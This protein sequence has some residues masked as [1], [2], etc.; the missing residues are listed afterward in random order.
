MTRKILMATAL[1]L[2]AAVPLT[3]A[4]PDAAGAPPVAAPKAQP[5]PA[6]P[7]VAPTP[8]T[9][10]TAPLPAAPPERMQ[11]ESAPA[12]TTTTTTTTT[13]ATPL[14]GACRTRKAEGE[15]CSCLKAP[16]VMG[17]STAPGNGGR[18]MCVVS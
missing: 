15:P 18:N 2:A 8:A 6:T 5:A 11:S 17:V 7:P 12:T 9:P 1:F 13:A 10:S 14:A 16:T 3:H 4:Q